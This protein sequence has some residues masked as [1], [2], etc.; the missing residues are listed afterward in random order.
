MHGKNKALPA[1]TNHLL[2]K[3]FIVNGKNQVSGQQCLVKG[4]PSAWCITA[5]YVHNVDFRVSFCFPV[6]VFYEG[7]SE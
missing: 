7:A 2:Q 4:H 6:T 5:Q 1:K 3:Q